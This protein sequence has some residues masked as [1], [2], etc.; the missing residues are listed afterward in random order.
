MT[1]DTSGGASAEQPSDYSA[2]GP[3][4]WSQP[5]PD[6]WTPPS[7]PAGPFGQPGSTYQAAEPAADQIPVGQI[8]GGQTPAGQTPVGQYPPAQFQT[9]QYP[10]GQ[11][12]TGQYPPGQYPTGQYGYQPQFFNPAPARNNPFAIAA[13]CC[14]VGQFILGLAIVLNILAAIPAIIFGAL[15]LRQIKLRGERGRGMAIAGLVLG[16]LGVVYFL[17]VIVVIIIGVNVHPGSGA[18]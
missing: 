17:L 10:P 14:G 12:P 15:A 11:F 6:S 1:S 9:G 5:A 4:Y 3:G 2:P 13:L 8:P 18:T 7:G 16:I